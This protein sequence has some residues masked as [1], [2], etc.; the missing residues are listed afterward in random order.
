M[1]QLLFI[2]INVLKIGTLIYMLQSTYAYSKGIFIQIHFFAL[3]CYNTLEL[4]R[5][6]AK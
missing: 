2:K 1:Y 4:A 5:I 3:L 6:K